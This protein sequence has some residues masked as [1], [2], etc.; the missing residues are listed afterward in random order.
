MLNFDDM[1][2]SLVSDRECEE[3]RSIN[4]CGIGCVG[5]SAD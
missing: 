5:A 1:A 4:F 2:L 3:A